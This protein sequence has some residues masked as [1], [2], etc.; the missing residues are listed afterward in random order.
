[1]WSLNSP[2]GIDKDGT[3]DIRTAIARGIT[4]MRW[5]N[6]GSLAGVELRGYP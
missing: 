1:M 4:S 5:G 6:D 3:E 2:S